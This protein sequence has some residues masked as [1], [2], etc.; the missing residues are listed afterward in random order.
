M[1]TPSRIFEVFDEK[2]GKKHLLYTRNLVPGEQ[3]YGERLLKSNGVEYREWEPFRSKL[4]ALILKGSPNIFIRKNDVVLYLGAASGTTVSHVSD[5]VG[6]EG[7]VFAV[8]FAPRVV[9]DLFFLS[10]KRKNLA[11]LLAD[12]NRPESLLQRMSLVDV[13][14]Q[15]IAQKN[16][17]DIFVKNCRMFLKDNGYALLA[18]KARSIDVTKIP[19]QIFSTVKVVLESEM[20]VVD[21]RELGPYQLDHCMFVCKKK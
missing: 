19:K 12:A 9:R 20:T 1:I 14:Y 4:A 18:V 5:I 21:Y 6:T 10:Q 7:F 2:A 8:D 15:D 3:V 13:V 11:P 17:V 16:Q